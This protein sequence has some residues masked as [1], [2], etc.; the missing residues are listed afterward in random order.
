[1]TKSIY[2]IYHPDDINAMLRASNLLTKAGLEVYADNPTS[3]TLADHVVAIR[4]A[5]GGQSDSMEQALRTA[6]NQ[7]KPVLTLDTGAN[8]DALDGNVRQLIATLAED[9]HS[10]EI[11]QPPSAG[12]QRAAIVIAVGVV[13]LAGVLFA[14][15]GSELDETSSLSVEP[16][17]AVEEASSS[18]SWSLHETDYVSVEIPNN[19]V[20]TRSSSLQISGYPGITE[21]VDL[22]F[23]D[24]QTNTGVSIDREPDV[25]NEPLETLQTI[26]REVFVESGATVEKSEIITLETGTTLY[27]RVLNPNLGFEDALQYIYI[28]RRN[29]NIYTVTVNV[30]PPFADRM[31]PTIDRIINSYRIR[32]L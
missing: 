8:N 32:D 10:T 28:T 5:R 25:N 13:A 2:I 20:T 30:D 6:R 23:Y 14:A 18:T 17:I 29:N 21:D 26:Y 31:Q 27:F 22:G 16:V 11:A 9:S 12:A 7:K 1:M 15:V 19:W 4:S 24:L 3:I